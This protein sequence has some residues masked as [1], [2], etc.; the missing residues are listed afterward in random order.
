MGQKDLQPENFGAG[1]PRA[2]ETLLSQMTAE[3]ENLQ[4][5]LIAQLSQDVERL[6]NEKSYLIDE[7]DRL[8][9]LRQQ[10]L[11]Q[12]QQ[13]IKQLAPALANQLQDLLAQRLQQMDNSAAPSKSSGGATFTRSAGATEYNENAYRL[14]ASLDSTL[15]STFKTLQQDLSSYQSSL[16]QQLGQMHSMEQQ[17]EAILEALVNR[18]R[19][20]ISKD[21]TPIAQATSAPPAVSGHPSQPDWELPIVPP[22]NHHPVGDRSSTPPPPIP[23]VPI[24][25][26]PESAAALPRS[27]PQLKNLS[28][29]QLGFLLVLVAS[30]SL[31]FFN[32]LIKIILGKPK[33]IFNE[34]TMGGFIAPGLGNSLLILWLR[35]LVV[36]PLMVVLARI[37]YPA[38]FRDIREFARFKDRRLVI[39]VIASGFFL[40]LSQ[41]LIYIALG[42]L[43]A[44][45]AITIFFIYPIVTVLFA[46]LLFGDRPTLF[47]SVVIFL[48]MLGV[49]LISLPTSGGALL[50]LSGI[51]AAAGSGIAF[52]FYVLL[53]QACAK[54]LNP[55]PLTLIHFLLIFFLSGLC[56]AGPAPDSWRFAVEPAAWPGLIISSLV[57]GGTTLVSYLLNN[58][59]ISIIGAARASILGAT[60]PALTALLA[61]II[62]GEALT[63]QQILGM[64]LVTLGVSALSFERLRRQTNKP[65]PAKSA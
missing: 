39:N 62:I 54:K 56:L 37:L 29:A 34:F 20:E 12:Q 55:V 5:N 61:L 2:A 22:D 43:S 13:L 31:S 59:G 23:P 1:D 10:Q 3:L 46:W 51:F 60:G 63:G 40:F 14:I 30:L 32:I 48:V 26:E 41:V 25:P 21:P 17:G 57:L 19:D 44:G 45:V 36:V 35:M 33:L 42:A 18:L 4:H 24:V 50:S 9:Q 27:T 38:V 6:Q 8:K 47:R 7:I 15:R 52:A 53:I 58:I 65:Q 11:T 16:S 28:N 64:L 49:I